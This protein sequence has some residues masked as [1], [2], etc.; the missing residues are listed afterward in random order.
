MILSDFLSRQTHN[1]NNPHEIIPISFN[2]YNTLC[3][4]YYSIEIEDWYLVQT[5]SQTKVT[6]I[7]LPE[8]HGAKKMLD[9]NVLP[10][11]QKPQIHREQVDKNRPR[12]RR[13]T[14]RIK[15]KKNPTCCWHDCISK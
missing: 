10:E 8:V 4:N 11:K 15:F 1:D 13:G 3:E 5:W 12:L 14:V 6:R 7:T 2:M 9:M